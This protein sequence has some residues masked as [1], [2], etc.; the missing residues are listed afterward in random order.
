[1]K[2]S[3]TKEQ[4]EKELGQGRAGLERGVCLDSLIEMDIERTG[5]AY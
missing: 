4:R 5:D 2:D 3:S 1:M